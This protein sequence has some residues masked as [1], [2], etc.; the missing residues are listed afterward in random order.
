MK[1]YDKSE[2]NTL[3]KKCIIRIYIHENQ[4]KIIQSYSKLIFLN[5]IIFYEL[6]ADKNLLGK[7]CF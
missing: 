1:K 6:K 7:F 3:M 5:L 2:N 4:I